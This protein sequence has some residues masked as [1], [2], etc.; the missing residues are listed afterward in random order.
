M[1]VYALAWAADIHWVVPEADM[2]APAAEADSLSQMAVPGASVWTDRLC[3]VCDKYRPVGEY[4]DYTWHHLLARNGKPAFP[5]RTEA[6][7]ASLAA[8]IARSSLPIRS[9]LK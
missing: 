4:N 1:E 2:T 7:L 5:N 9:L 8:R 3:D 6:M